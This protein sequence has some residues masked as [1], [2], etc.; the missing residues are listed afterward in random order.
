MSFPEYDDGEAQAGSQGSNA[1]MIRWMIGNSIAA[2]PSTVR[3]HRVWTATCL[4][5]VPAVAVRLP[6]RRL[7]YTNIFCDNLRESSI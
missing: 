2:P 6:W 4:C 3:I 1:A 7:L 5:T